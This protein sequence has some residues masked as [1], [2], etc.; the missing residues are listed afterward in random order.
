VADKSGKPETAAGAAFEDDV[1]E[2]L[3]EFTRQLKRCRTVGEMLNL[4]RRTRP[5]SSA[6]AAARAAVLEEAG[7]ESAG[8]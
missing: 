7:G 6:H 2:S 5:G 4:F 8:S 1:V 3:R